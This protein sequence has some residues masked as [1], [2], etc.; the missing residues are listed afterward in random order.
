MP[1]HQL[2]WHNLKEQQVLK[3]VDSNIRGLDDKEIKKRVK[4]FGY[5]I[6]VQKKSL[7]AWKI[8]AGQ[9]KSALVYVLLIGAVISFLFKEVVDAYVIILAVVLNVIIGFLQEYKANNSL[10]KLSQVIKQQAVV[11]RD[12][13]QQ[14]IDAKFLLPG[15]IVI[16][17]AGDKVSADI[18]LLDSTN[19]SISEAA[20]TGESWPIKKIT[21]ALAIGTV[22]A[23]RKN[24]AY[25]G[26]VISEGRGEGVV[27]G[28]GLSTELG[29]IAKLLNEV[30]N[31][32]T[33]LQVK[34]DKFA[35]TITTIIVSVAF[36]VMLLGLLQGYHW[37][38]IFTV[39]VALAV[40]AIPEG[41]LI[42][43]TVIL[44][45]G[46]QRILKNN[47]LV[48]Q[49]VSAETLGATT[50]ICADKTGTLTEGEMRVTELLSM[51]RHI[52]F[53]AQ[54]IREIKW[55][56]DMSL[57]TDIAILC[58][59]AVVQNPD[60]PNK[61]W[62][63][64][65]TPTEKALL[66]FGM[67]YS[68]YHLLQK[69][70]RLE[71]I[72]FD[73]QYKFMVTRHAHDAEKDII[74]VKGAP[75]III[76][77]AT[78]HTDNGQVVSQDDRSRKI[79]HEKVEHLSKRGLRV[80]AAAYRLVPKNYP[81]DINVKKELSNLT[82]VGLWG[83]IDPIRPE[84]SETFE[85]TRKADI[86]TVM[87]TGDSK[88][89]AFHIAQSLKLATANDQVVTGDELA[90]M[91]DQ[92]LNDRV[93]QIKVYARVTPSDKLRIIQAWKARGEVVAMTGDGVNDA[94]ALKAADVGVT[95]SSASDIA[96]EVADLVLLDNNFKTIV[97]SI[98]EGRLIFAN[99]KKVILYLLSDSFVKITI[100]ATAMFLGY[101]LPIL[102][103]HIL[104]IKLITDGLPSLALT[105]EPEDEDIMEHRE[106]PGNL[107]LD[108]EGKFLI[109]IISIL[110][111]LGS[112][113]LFYFFWKSTGDL[114]LAR[115]ITFV[116]SG[117]GTLLYV[118]SVKNLDKNIFESNPFKNKYLN[119][120]VIIGILLQLVAVYLP[121]LN[122]FIKTVPLNWWHWQ[123]IIL[124][125]VVLFI[126]LELIK[127]V[128][129]RYNKRHSK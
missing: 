17:R 126:L 40:S 9:F 51:K 125:T 61:H 114:A 95:V 110:Y 74:Y 16:L 48:R 32:L 75:E 92:Q 72:P 122:H 83:L 58:N 85:Q 18:R 15:D 86:K 101:P 59:D 69:K 41:L 127:L 109:L 3:E 1:K 43:L 78:K 10:E 91:S 73:S 113:S 30:E 98:K 111:A 39:A 11:R 93:E 77:S 5:N 33:P 117:I 64:F 53:Q 2:E 79:W 37:V 34:L 100:I 66:L 63:I 67:T 14:I 102:T 52:D 19:L 44:T 20:L 84:M 119:I 94:P 8:F 21:T 25:M 128:F 47:G 23:E 88:F 56:K 24:M 82:M 4:T 108:F 28:I 35:K 49:L 121:F 87:I 54:T 112:L 107:L 50:V 97:L 22:L 71:E 46:M 89:T 7:T 99:L 38:E 115:T 36:V 105:M 123:A 124:M 103:T 42:S 60:D 129:I 6:L 76:P 13:R 31:D 45:V 27:I 80:L 106:P 62:E 65:G 70:T 26:T 81:L 57:L 55:D 118:Y 68:D 12:N 96:K 90:K 116:S 29:K 104:W 120:A